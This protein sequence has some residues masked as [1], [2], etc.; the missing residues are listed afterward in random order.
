MALVDPGVLGKSKRSPQQ[1]G[2]CTQGTVH[3]GWEV[4]VGLPVGLA[5]CGVL[6]EGQGP[7]ESTHLQLD[8]WNHSTECLPCHCFEVQ[9]NSSEVSVSGKQ[10]EDFYEGTLVMLTPPGH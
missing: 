1:A 3:H 8:I 6:P 9:D 10:E 5:L 4:L 7:V 2:T